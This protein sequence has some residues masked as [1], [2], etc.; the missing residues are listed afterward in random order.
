MNGGV[1]KFLQGEVSQL[2]S[3]IQE[4]DDEVSRDRVHFC[5][6][7]LSDQPVCSGD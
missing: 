3:N 4:V 1:D 2:I 6:G 7:D 5:F